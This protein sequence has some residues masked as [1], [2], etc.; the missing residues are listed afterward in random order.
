M[1]RSMLQPGNLRRESSLQRIQNLAQSLRNHR[2]QSESKK[3]WNLLNNKI[4]HPQNHRSYP[5][6]NRLKMQLFVER[7]YNTACQKSGPS[8]QNWTLRVVAIGRKMITMRTKQAA[9]TMRTNLDD[10]QEKLWMKN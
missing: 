4:L 6:T 8:W 2:Q 5:S 10:Q 9:W 1:S 7:C 3:S